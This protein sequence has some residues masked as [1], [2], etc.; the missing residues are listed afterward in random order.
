[1]KIRVRRSYFAVV[2]TTEAAAERCEPERTQETNNNHC[3]PCRKRRKQKHMYSF[4][5]FLHWTEFIHLL[6][7]NRKRSKF[8]SLYIHLYLTSCLS[9]SSVNDF[10]GSH[11]PYTYVRWMAIEESRAVHVMGDMKNVRPPPLTIRIWLGVSTAE[12]SVRSYF[13]YSICLWQEWD[14]SLRQQ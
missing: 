1:M 6:R 7:V 13:M 8:I 9:R 11:P 10:S 12:S 4:R 14:G 2:H 5:C 3:K